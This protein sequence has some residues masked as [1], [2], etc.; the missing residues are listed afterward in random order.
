MNWRIHY[1]PK[2]E[3]KTTTISICTNM[4]ENLTESLTEFKKNNLNTEFSCTQ[5]LP[6]KDLSRKEARSSVR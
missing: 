6:D 2:F 4:N 5:P 1:T 3:K